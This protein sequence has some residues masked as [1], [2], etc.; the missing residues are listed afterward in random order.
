MKQ[1]LGDIEGGKSDERKCD[2]LLPDSIS[3][4]DIDVWRISTDTFQHI[5]LLMTAVMP[6]QQSFKYPCWLITATSLFAIPSNQ[7]T[8]ERSFIAACWW[9]WA[10]ILCQL[11]LAG[12][13]VNESWAAYMAPNAWR[14][15]VGCNSPCCPHPGSTPMTGNIVTD[16]RSFKLT[17][18]IWMFVHFRGRRI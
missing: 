4:Q 9:I 12:G 16:S 18:I 5:S 13:K 8:A 7:N 3:K 17:R 11:T 14:P 1:N 10:S 15:R 2:N 6:N